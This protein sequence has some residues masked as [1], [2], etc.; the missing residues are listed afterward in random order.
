MVR[1]TVTFPAAERHRPLTSTKSYCLVTAARVSRACPESLRRHAAISGVEPVTSGLQVWHQWRKYIQATVDT[2]TSASNDH[3]ST[4]KQINR[5]WTQIY[6]ADRYIINTYCN[7]K[8]FICSSDFLSH[9]YS[10][11]QN[12]RRPMAYKPIYEGNQW[13]QMIKQFRQ[14]AHRRGQ[15]FRGGGNFVWMHLYR[16]LQYCFLKYL[17]NR[18]L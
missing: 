11:I 4:A 18:R 2:V 5:I 16:R 17:E 14:E 15:V 3:L 6:L 1:P 7:N 9:E 10:W 8:H 13:K 12:C